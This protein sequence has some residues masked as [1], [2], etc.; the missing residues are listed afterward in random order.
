MLLM[1]TCTDKVRIVFSL[2]SRQPDPGAG[3]QI[4]E[5][6]CRHAAESGRRRCS[7]GSAAQADAVQHCN[8][9]AG[10]AHVSPKWGSTANRSCVRRGLSGCK[11]Q[12]APAANLRL[13]S[14]LNLPVRYSTRS[15]MTWPTLRCCRT[16]PSQS[17]ATGTC[18]REVTRAEG[19]V[20][21]CKGPQSLCTCFHICRQ[22]WASETLVARKQGLAAEACR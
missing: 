8:G 15:S 9:S 14:R 22:T 2:H 17:L 12:N 11:D 13:G 4:D 5:P 19:L 20:E 3:Q 6:D 18:S 16:T 10:C 21:P 7:A 1:V